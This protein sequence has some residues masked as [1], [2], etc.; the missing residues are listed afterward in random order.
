M[1]E[2]R[3]RTVKSPFSGTHEAYHTLAELFRPE[4]ELG[5]GTSQDD[6]FRPMDP[7]VRFGPLA[8]FFEE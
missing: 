2:L 1:I 6:S 5:R 7:C 4:D 8:R 3:S